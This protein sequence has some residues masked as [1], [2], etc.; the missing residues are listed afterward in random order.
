MTVALRN[1]WR[2][3]YW[4]QINQ[5]TNQEEE[6]KEE[7][8]EEIEEESNIYHCHFIG[9]EGKPLNDILRLANILDMAK[10]RYVT[11][12]ALAEDYEW[13]SEINNGNFT[14]N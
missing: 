5:P 7:E 1:P 6:E 11:K 8:E 3:F 4:P 9:K 14:S 10:Q 2:N 12:L 13:N